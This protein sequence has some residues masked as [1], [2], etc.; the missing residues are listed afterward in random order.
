MIRVPGAMASIFDEDFMGSKSVLPWLV[1]PLLVACALAPKERLLAPK[2]LGPNSGKIAASMCAAIAQAPASSP[3]WK[4][5]SEDE[6]KQLRSG[7]AKEAKEKSAGHQTGGFLRDGKAIVDGD[8]NAVAY[9]LAP[10]AP[11]P[12]VADAYVACMLG[13]GYRWD[14]TR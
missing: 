7:L 4:T 2:G 3:A 11:D 5:K 12:A 6:V 1:A 9:E 10:S 13:L 14:E 8:G